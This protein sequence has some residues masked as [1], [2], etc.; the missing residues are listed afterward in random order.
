MEVHFLTNS[1]SRNTQGHNLDHQANKDIDYSKV[2][3]PRNKQ[4]ILEIWFLALAY[5]LCYNLRITN[6]FLPSAQM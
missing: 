5:T 3:P 6:R 1:C 4:R 2:R